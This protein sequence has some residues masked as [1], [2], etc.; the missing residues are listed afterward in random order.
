M[1]RYCTKYSSL[2]SHSSQL[3]WKLASALIA[4]HQPPMGP[5]HLSIPL[6]LLRSTYHANPA[7]NL[8]ELIKPVALSDPK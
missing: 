3:E 4:A 1:L 2:V 5:A 6:D 8:A 7:Y